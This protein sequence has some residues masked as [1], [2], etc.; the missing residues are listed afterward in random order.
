MAQLCSML[1]RIRQDARQIIPSKSPFRE[2]LSVIMVF[3]SCQSDKY[4]GRNN[5]AKELKLHDVNGTSNSPLLAEVIK[6]LS[7]S[8]NGEVHLCDSL[9]NRLSLI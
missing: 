3:C 6:R 4:P 2:A 8:T 5:L 1:C 9:V 7:P